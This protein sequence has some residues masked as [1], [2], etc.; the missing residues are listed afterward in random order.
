[1]EVDI[2][3]H[4]LDDYEAIYINGK[5]TGQNNDGTLSDYLSS[6][7]K[8]PLTI[9]TYSIQY[10]IDDNIQDLVK[11]IQEEASDWEIAGQDSSSR[12]Q[13]SCPS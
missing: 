4:A 8:L 6:V 12:S 13:G 7:G 9:K 3:I 2:E 10:H 5:L 1:M 11:S